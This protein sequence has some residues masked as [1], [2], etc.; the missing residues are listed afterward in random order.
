[1]KV[2]SCSVARER[3]LLSDRVIPRELSGDYRRWE[4]NSFEEQEVETAPAVPESQEMP[5]LTWPTAEEIEQ[6][7]QQA[8]ED[9]LTAGRKEGLATGREEGLAA[10]R[11]EGL[12]AGRKEGY[13]A[14][15]SEGYESGKARLLEETARFTQLMAALEEA[16]AG[17]DELMGAE[18][19]AVALAIA[20]QITRSALDFRPEALLPV[21]REALAGLPQPG[22]HAQLILHPDDAELVRSLMGDELAHMHC[23]IVESNQLERGGCLV[24]TEA[25]EIDATLAGRWSRVIATLGRNDAWLT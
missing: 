17:F 21:I 10:G 1:M 5:H 18:M 7:Q 8:H 6:I 3:I 11:E 15:W 25:S 13:D 12:A 19:L 24:K 9:G 4:L 23:R 2:R 22:A 14:G 20:R 16:L